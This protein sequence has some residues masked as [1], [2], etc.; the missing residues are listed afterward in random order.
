MSAENASS[1][2]S[3][4]FV[5]YTDQAGLGSFSVDQVD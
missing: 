4:D 2:G 1:A 5:G 3:P